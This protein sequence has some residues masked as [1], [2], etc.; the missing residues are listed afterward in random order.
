MMKTS[1][2][3]WLALLTATVAEAAINVPALR[4]LMTDSRFVGLV[5]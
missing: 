5:S 4:L 2:R 1:H 3:F